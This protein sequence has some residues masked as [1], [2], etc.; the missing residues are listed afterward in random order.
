VSINVP[1]FYDS[2][3]N[4]LHHQSLVVYQEK[5]KVKR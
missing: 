4:N 3:K 5:Q 1:S 2:T